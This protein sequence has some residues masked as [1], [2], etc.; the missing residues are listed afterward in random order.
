M[1]YNPKT[2]CLQYQPPIWG[3]ARGEPYD[4]QTPKNITYNISHPHGGKREGGPYD[5]QTPKQIAFNIS[6]PHGGKR[7]GGL[8]I[9][10]PKNRLP[11][12]SATHMGGN[13]RGAL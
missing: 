8:M 3:E 5:L 7:E 1:T 9:Y 4:L 2:D 11:T 12:I 10:K 6:H 13:E